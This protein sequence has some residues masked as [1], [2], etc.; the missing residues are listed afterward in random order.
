MLKGQDDAA[1]GM[2]IEDLCL[3]FNRPYTP[4]LAVVFWD[5]LKHLRIDEV[6]R[7]CESARKN[8]KRFPTPKELL[9]ERRMPSSAQRQPDD[10]AFSRWAMAANRI[11]FKLAYEDDRRGFLPL[12]PEL[13]ARCLAVKA[14]YVQMAEDAQSGGEPWADDDFIAMCREGFEKLLGTHERAAA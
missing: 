4:R 6:K 12:G 10:R 1:F 13:L 7:A 5:V 3:A 14:D 11:L 8:L 2:L 9:P